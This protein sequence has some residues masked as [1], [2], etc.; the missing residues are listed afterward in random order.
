MALRCPSQRRFLLE[1]P[2]EKT[3]DLLCSIETAKV[4]FCL[5]PGEPFFF[6]FRKKKFPP[7]GIFLKEKL[8]LLFV[9]LG[10][11]GTNLVGQGWRVW[12]E[13]KY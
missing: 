12:A 4:K 3:P 11:A 9:E 8:N 1:K 10:L 5:K 7:K 2:E 6:L 13:Y